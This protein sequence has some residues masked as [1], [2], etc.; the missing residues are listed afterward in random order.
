MSQFMTPHSPNCQNQRESGWVL[1]HPLSKG[2]VGAP[3]TR[4]RQTLIR[5]GRLSMLT[6]EIV[7]AAAASEIKTGRRVGLNWN[8][9]KLEYSQFGRQRCNHTIK[10]L[11]GPGGIGL[12][13]CFDDIYDVNPRMFEH[14]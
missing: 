8:M 12:G 5:L 14:S 1:P 7:S 10:P 13:A 11:Y 3:P 6:P 2:L 4:N 9:R